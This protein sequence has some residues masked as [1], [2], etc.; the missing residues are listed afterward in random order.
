MIAH[1]FLQIGFYFGEQ[2]LPRILRT[3]AQL[4]DSLWKIE[5]EPELADGSSGIGRA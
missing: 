3:Q 1:F 5:Q 2:E 4:F